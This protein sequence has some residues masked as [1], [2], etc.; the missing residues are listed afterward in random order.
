MNVQ[1]C[2]EKKLKNKKLFVKNYITYN[3][4]EVIRKIKTN[5]FKGG[6]QSY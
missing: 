2:L 6:A 3:D 5:N 4:F 1:S